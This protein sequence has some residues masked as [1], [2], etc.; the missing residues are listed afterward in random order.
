MEGMFLTRVL[1][2]EIIGWRICA[3]SDSVDYTPFDK[4]CGKGEFKKA[5]ATFQAREMTPYWRYHS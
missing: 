2:V 1:F 3:F 4:Y 5:Y